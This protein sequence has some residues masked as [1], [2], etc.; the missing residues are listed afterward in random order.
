MSDRIEALL[1]L[2]T[3]EA[4]RSWLEQHVPARDGALVDALREEALRRERDNPHTALLVSQAAADA[5][6]VWEDQQTEAASLHIEAN[7]R[8]LLAEHKVALGLYERATM[9]YNALGLELEA[10]R[11]AV[12]QLNAMMYLGLYE[13]AL[14]LAD[15]ASDVFHV[16]G[17][18]SALGRMITNRGNIFAR[19]GR[20]PEARDSYAQAR[21]V[22]TALGD[23]RRMA[24]LDVNDANVQAELDDFR[25]AEEMLEQARVQFE[26]E[27]LTSLVAQVDLNLGYLYFARGDY[28]RAL[29]TFN[30]ARD[31][32]VAQDD[33]VL[34]AKVDW[35]RSDTYLALNLWHEA[36]ER[37]REARLAFEKAG[38]AWEVAV[39]WLNEAAALAHLDDD[40][41]PIDA[42]DGAR[43][44]FAQ[45]QNE[46][47]LAATDLYQATFDWR[48]RKLVSARE[49]ALRARD[50][51]RQARLR[52]RV[53]QCEVILGEVA[54]MLGE[55]E[56]AAK[57]F[58]Q[59]L[60]Q[61][62]QTNAP[63]VCFACLFGL[64]R[65]EQRKG[66]IEAARQHYRQAIIAIE[67]LQAA[68]GAEDYKMAFLS[69]KL[70]VYE[71]LI[72]LLLNVGTPEAIQEAFE[73]VEQAKSRAL[74]DALA[75]EAHAPV[76]SPAEAE[77]LDEMERLK[78]ELNWYYNRLNTPQPDGG[79]LSIE[80]V[81][82]MTEAITRRERA[83]KKL[84]DRWRSPDLAS[85]PHNPIWTVTSDQ[86]QAI[87]PAKSLLL[88]FYTAKDQIIVFGLNAETMWMHRLPTSHSKVVETLIQLR[89]QINKFGYGPAYQ[90]RH[91]NALRQGVDESL[92]EL[93]KAL[94]SPI[95]ERLTAET[96]TIV[97]HGVLH[98]VPFQ[99]LFDGER[100]L[101]D[102]KTVSYA[103]SA[104]ILH[105]I[106]TSQAEVNDSVPLII[107]LPDQMI[108]YAQAE[109]ESIAALFSQADVYLGERATMDSLMG[110]ERSPA[111]LHLSTHATF[112]ADNPLF[113]ALKLADGWVSVNDIYSMVKSAPLVTLSACETGRSQ[114]AAG[115]ELVGLC[116]GFFSA[117]A[118]SLV[119]SLWRVDDSSTAH[120]MARFYEGL[121]D[122]QP[123][124]RALRAAQMAVKG[125]KGH[126]YYWAPFI[127][128]GDI[129]THLLS[130]V[131]H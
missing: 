16:A 94:L 47:W 61:F 2:D 101:I 98:Y 85:A 76:D 21:I 12:G 67:R 23:T 33:T 42:L 14:A 102:E 27:S 74:L 115:D 65:T 124:N 122:G 31:T 77:L 130:T 128:T 7:V 119:V 79:E 29:T 39:L 36:L 18:Q 17:D 40:S 11:V 129:H 86:I 75:R 35:H 87:L 72:L 120:L 10:A 105:R 100:Y 62:E 114:V 125:E 58:H 127:L 54:L 20:F 22:F 4:R 46:V 90:E 9:L 25:V 59:G 68:I 108:P 37:A 41:S 55:I 8:W 121:R 113:S 97:P 110:N 34:T 118:R 63:S 103:P 78:S 88:E 66:Q 73:T 111:F 107:G 15:W 117:G 56:H 99:A 70:Q 95:A 60:A 32:F 71:A 3:S 48:S 131:N 126:A 84:L 51:F 24:M 1:S 64:G 69:D 49:H 89:F 112:R 81:R 123:V 83:L 93:Y 92:H 5:A 45:E 6:L 116:R 57:H 52:S 96:L 43:Q 28:Q 109:V 82:R 53:T 104:T 38:M 26:I 80:E 30:Q 50:V 91:A 106:L 44:I 13:E 19:L